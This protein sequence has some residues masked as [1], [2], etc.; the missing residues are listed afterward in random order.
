MTVKSRH[1]DAIGSQ[2]LDD[3]ID[4]VA[5]QH[6]V[7]GDRGLSAAGWLK[8]KPRRYTQRADWC[9]HHS[10]FGDWV[11][12]WHRKLIDA[13]IG[14]ALDTNDLVKLRGVEIN[15]RRGS[16]R[17]RRLERGLAVRQGRADR[18]CHLDRIAATADVQVEGRGVRT[19]QVIM[20]RRDL[21]PV[22]DQLGHHGINLAF[23]EHEIAHRHD[24][25][26]CRSGHPFGMHR[27]EC[28]PAAKRQ[29]RFDGDPIEGDGKVSARKAV[30]VHVA[31]YDG[32]FAAKSVIDIL[33]VDLLSA[34]D[35]RRH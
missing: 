17:S 3:W 2:R 11:T 21:D 9:D 20:Y 13:A 12:P 28:Y 18:R 7:A 32:S 14:L 8:A 31:G 5:S 1:L 33:P 22:L 6:K 35:C 4:L 10:G 34:S 15:R 23:Q 29:S 26:A 27:L 25:G 19:K 30:P 24:F 16:R